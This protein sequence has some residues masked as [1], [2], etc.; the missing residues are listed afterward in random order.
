MLLVTTIA[1]IYINIIEDQPSLREG[2]ENS[3]PQA[4]CWV[5]K[6]MNTAIYDK[7]KEAA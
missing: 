2:C 1:L 6:K 7:L 5:I 4:M 3:A